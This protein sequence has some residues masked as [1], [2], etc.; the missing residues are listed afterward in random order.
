MG[1]QLVISQYG[2][3]VNSVDGSVACG[4]L[5]KEDGGLLLMGADLQGDLLLLDGFELAA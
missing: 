1:L 4:V 2:H 3:G 5:I